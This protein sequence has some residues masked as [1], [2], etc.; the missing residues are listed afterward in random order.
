MSQLRAQARELLATLGGGGAGEVRR[1]SLEVFAEGRVELVTV[2]VQLDGRL[3]VAATDGASDGAHVR[4]ALRMLAGLASDVGEDSREPLVPSPS[5]A[6]SATRH[7]LGEALDELLL[8]VARHGVDAATHAAS[9]DEAMDRLVELAGRSPPLGLARFAG[10]LRGALQRRDAPL[11]ARLLDGA[12]RVASLLRDGPADAH[13]RRMLGLWLGRPDDSDT[14][15]ETIYDRTLVEVGREWLAG[16]TRASIQRRY[17]VCTSSGEVFREERARA[18]AGSVGSCPRSISAGL[19]EVEL[20]GAP[21]SIRLL[22]YAVTPRVSADAWARVGELAVPSVDEL[23]PRF[24]VATKAS[25]AL[26]EPFA[27]VAAKALHGRSLEDPAGGRIPLRGGPAGVEAR[28]A[29]ATAVGS[30]RWVAGRIDDVDG[31]LALEP[32]ALATEVDGKM[33]FERLR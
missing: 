29:A 25:P 32:F 13:A 8:A 7:P 31:V 12:A 6:E 4:V 17:L 22:Q 10:R 9:L 30:L 20:V 28:V 19:A 18:D 16:L 27:V 24:R 23:R 15:R 3:L 26:A 21:R 33:V 2:S 14:P 11:V 5:P 1:V